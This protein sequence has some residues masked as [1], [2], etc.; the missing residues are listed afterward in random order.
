MSLRLSHLMAK[1]IHIPG[2][3]MDWRP[4][5]LRAGGIVGWLIVAA[6]IGI[7]LL[8]GA[9]TVGPSEIA[10]VKRFG[11]FVKQTGPGFHFRLPTPIES[12]VFIDQQSVRT[13]EIGF[14]SKS[15]V[16]STEYA[17]RE[18]EALMLTGDFN[19][20]RVETVVQYDV[21]DAVMFAFR[22]ENARSILR[23]AAQAVIRERVALR[24]VDEALTEKREEIA[25]AIHDELQKMMNDYK[26]GVRIINVRLQEV[27]P[28]TQQVAAA[29]DDVNSAIQDKERL[30]FEAKRYTNEQM[31][32][33]TG[34]AQRIQNEA[35]GYKQ[36]RILQAEGDVARFLAVLNRYKA[37]DTVTRDRLYIET[38]ENVLPGLKKV[39]VTKEGAGVLKVLDLDKLMSA[40]PEGGAR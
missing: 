12:V 4:G 23:E 27:T 1:E 7:W 32:R 39:I 40:K 34:M 20:I 8:S 15:G 29:F 13:E 18:D 16:P 26:T 11:K 10:L 2:A 30:I 28:P 38:M 36:S 3:W 21:S 31:P 19:V 17:S 24:K 5:F 22:V 6:L 25:A 33:A 35:E 14:R 9:Y 37:G